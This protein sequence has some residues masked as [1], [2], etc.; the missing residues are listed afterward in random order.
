MNEFQ[1]NGVA[2]ALEPYIDS[3]PTNNVVPFQA[4]SAS[5]VGFQGKPAAAFANLPLESLAAGLET[6]IEEIRSAVSAIPPS[7]IS[8]EPEWMKLARALAW[9]AA[10]FPKRKD[11]L[12]EILDTA[13]RRAPGYDKEDNQRRF[14]R[15]ISEAGDHENPIT[16]MTVFHMALDH[17][18]DGKSS[19]LVTS[20]NTLGS[21]VEPTAWPA[22][23]LKVSFSN[24]PH[25]QWLYGTY[26]IRGEITVV[27]AP[28]GAGKTALATG[29]AVEIATGKELLGEKI[30]GG[31]NLKV[32]FVNAEDSGTEIRRRVWAF[33]LAHADKIAGQTLD[34]LYVA[35]ADDARVQKL[36]FLRTTDR[37]VSVLDQ[38][39]FQVLEAALQSLRPDV[40]ILDPLV[41][42]CGG[43]NMNDN[44]VMSLVMRELKRVATSFNCAVLIVHHTRKGGDIGN[45]EAISGAAATVNLSRRAI[46]PVPMTNEDAQ[47]LK[48]LPSQRHRYFKVVDAKSNLAPRSH[49]SP[50]YELHELPNP[51]PPIYPFGD[52]VQAVARVTLPLVDNISVTADDQKTRR[53][54]LDLVEHGKIIEGQR[55]PYSPNVTGAK[56]ERALLDDAIVAVTEA[57][58]PQ[59]WHPGDLR[60]VVKREIERLKSDKWLV[61]GENIKGPRFR[62]GNTL[63]VDWSRTP[64]ANERD[65]APSPEASNNFA[66]EA[67]EGEDGQWSMAW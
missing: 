35:G 15:Y 43:G 17:G 18:W 8:T 31:D 27:A 3:A 52:S 38:N 59:Q 48:V 49:D 65:A 21:E 37:N 6:N 24:I 44:A 57:T 53:A 54:I 12:W 19:P 14:D 42:F 63:S 13:S 55:Y 40:V 51:Q 30:W 61:E 46:M 36:S 5:R 23:E 29:M 58:A 9:E 4:P 7:A 34:R 11:T 45:A 1:E 10:L 2:K 62:R 33:C 39:G 32:L 56:N 66:D 22:A 50:W 41:A 64:W 47:Q 60:A 25:R 67:W 28:G 20:A 16:I 26:L